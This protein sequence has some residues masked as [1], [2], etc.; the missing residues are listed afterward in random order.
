M[1]KEYMLIF[2]CAIKGEIITNKFFFD[3]EEEM[4]NFVRL[5]KIT[6]N[7]KVESAFKLEKLDNN[8]FT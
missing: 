1:Y 7:I 3:T 8:I 2:Q 5:S 6:G 4:I